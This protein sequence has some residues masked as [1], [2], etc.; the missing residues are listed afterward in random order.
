MAVPGS[1][2]IYARVI[3]VACI[4]SEVKFAPSRRKSKGPLPSCFSN[5]NWKQSRRNLMRR[6]LLSSFILDIY[7]YVLPI[8]TK[9]SVP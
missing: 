6:A 4:K 9:T 8:M 1:M 5:E 7:I 2:H 3:E